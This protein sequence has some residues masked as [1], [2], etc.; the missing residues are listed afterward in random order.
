MSTGFHRKQLTVAE[1]QK[2]D[3]FTCDELEL[4]EGA[5]LEKL[6]PHDV[7]MLADLEDEL[8]RSHE[9]NFVRVVPSADFEH[10]V[11]PR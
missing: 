10:F 1:Q 8:A 11:P 5:I 6:L 7:T 3:I 9:T 4:R 2:R